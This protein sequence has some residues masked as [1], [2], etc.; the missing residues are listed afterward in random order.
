MQPSIANLPSVNVILF[1]Q[2]P[3]KST[4]KSDTISNSLKRLT[5]FFFIFRV[6]SFGLIR[7]GSFCV[8]FRSWKIR[9]SRRALFPKS[10]HI[11]ARWLLLFGLIYR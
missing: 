11:V 8:P 3:L 9:N 1:P 7:A 2:P 6:G 4:N 5:G 10:L